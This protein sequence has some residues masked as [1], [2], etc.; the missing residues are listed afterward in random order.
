M[1]EKLKAG[2]TFVAAEVPVFVT[3]TMQYPIANLNTDAVMDVKED[4]RRTTM[5]IDDSSM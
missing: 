1:M 3:R 5:G 2:F 4:P